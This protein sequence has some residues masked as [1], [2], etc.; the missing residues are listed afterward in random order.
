MLERG[1][2]RPIES[3]KPGSRLVTQMPAEPSMEGSGGVEPEV[4]GTFLLSSL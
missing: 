4:F 3:L 1:V 2:E